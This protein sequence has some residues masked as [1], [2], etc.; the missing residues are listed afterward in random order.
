MPHGGFRMLAQTLTLRLRPMRSLVVTFYL[1]NN[2]YSAP[3]KVGQLAASSLEVVLV[4]RKDR[5]RT[6]LSIS[7]T[8]V[9][10]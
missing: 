10:C 4:D 3:N 7:L 1:Q 5:L 2:G 8:I 6:R 9:S